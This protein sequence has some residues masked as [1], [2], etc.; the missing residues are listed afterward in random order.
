MLGATSKICSELLYIFFTK[1]EAEQALGV[2]IDYKD[3]I[4]ILKMLKA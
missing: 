3:T 1:V 4:H 2:N